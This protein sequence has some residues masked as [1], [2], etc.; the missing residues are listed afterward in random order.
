MNVS[1]CTKGLTD[2]IGDP[3]LR[4]YLKSVAS[5]MKGYDD[6]DWRGLMNYLNRALP[7]YGTTP[8]FPFPRSARKK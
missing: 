6:G 7:Q 5:I 4:E 3:R 1:S 2:E 8:E